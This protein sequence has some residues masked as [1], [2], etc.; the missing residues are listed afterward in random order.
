M[1]SSIWLMLSEWIR[2]NMATVSSSTSS[3][4]IYRVLPMSQALYTPPGSSV[5]PHKVKD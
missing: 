3:V 4:N 5:V 2:Q 1:N